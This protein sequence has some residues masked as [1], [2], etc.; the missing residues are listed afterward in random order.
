MEKLINKIEKEVKSR[1]SIKLNLGVALNLEESQ[2]LVDGYRKLKELV[3]NPW[4]SVEDRLPSE[5]EKVLWYDKMFDKVHAFALDYPEM[6]DGDFTHWMPLPNK[7][8]E[9]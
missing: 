4:V 8:T 7:P 9:R 5:G 3:E 6:H 1:L 2:K